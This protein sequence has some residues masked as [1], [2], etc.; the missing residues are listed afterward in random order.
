MRKAVS[1]AGAART[2]DVL[3]Y[4]VWAG[5]V[6]ECVDA[7]LS[8]VDAGERGVFVACANP[9]SLEVARRQPAFAA[10][11]RSADYLLP[12]GVGIVLAS[13]LQGGR[14]RRR[15]TGTDFFLALSRRLAGR[16][17]GAAFYLGAAP[18]TLEL[19]R[20]RHERELAGLRF[21]GALSPPFKP[22]FDEGE[23][24]AMAAAVAAVRP[25]ILWV[26]MTAPKQETWVA[27]NRGRLDAGCVA[28]VGAVFDF[29]AGT[30][31]RPSPWFTERGL[32]WL[33]RLLGEPRRLW[34]RTLVSAPAFL[35][36]VVAGRARGRG[37]R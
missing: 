27:A 11:L 9:H 24:A 17:G 2:E 37:A 15:V 34:R 21:G 19:L 10:A 23:S 12:D 20:G 6:E 1:G 30:V 18:R 33:P 36:R 7:V 13:R 26:G 28:A 3:G 29:Y 25:A 8:R 22:T 4:A 16:G 5:S 35:A 32:E 31:R 14:I